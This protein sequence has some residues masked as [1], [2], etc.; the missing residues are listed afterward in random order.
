MP[1]AQQARSIGIEDFDHGCPISE[2]K[3]GRI[4]RAHADAIP[5]LVAGIPE[6]TRARLAAF[7]YA[8]T[9]TR[10]LGTRVAATCDQATLHHVAGELGK[11]IHRQSCQGYRG[12]PYGNGSRLSRRSVSLARSS[13][14]RD[15]HP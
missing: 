4:Y 12:G 7:L 1:L 10:E 9:H 11:A 13:I 2:D 14:V 8:R 6:R 5:D 3:L 15:Q